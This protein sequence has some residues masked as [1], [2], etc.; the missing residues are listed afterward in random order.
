LL[1][2]PIVLCRLLV[3]IATTACL[4]GAS[5]VAARTEEAF[6]CESAVAM[7]LSRAAGRCRG[8]D[9]N[10]VTCA[11]GSVNSARARVEAMLTRFE[12][13]T[14]PDRCIPGLCG[15]ADT[16]ISCAGKLVE[17]A[18]KPADAPLSG[19]RLRDLQ[20]LKKSA[21]VFRKLARSTA[22]CRRRASR[23]LSRARPFDVDAC[24]DDVVT[25]NQDRLERL[26]ERFEGKGASAI[27]C[28]LGA[29][30]P[31]DDASICVDLALNGSE[32]EPEPGTPADPGEP[33]DLTADER[34]CREQS[35]VILREFDERVAK[36]HADLESK[37]AN[38]DFPGCLHQARDKRESKLRGFLDEHVR[39]E[40]CLPGICTAGQSAA[41][42]AKTVLDLRAPESATP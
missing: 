27:R 25:A 9:F 29:C 8:K 6:A 38:F 28:V 14:S 22:K 16:P 26:V 31:D 39:P 35:A 21:T 40:R 20:C 15:A 33:S 18:G 36:C 12:S 7:T 11:S 30:T 24:L 41:A 17:G 23:E 42:C 2:P 19:W 3:L 37:G 32:D 1:G 5:P 13:A 10:G 34:E 4:L